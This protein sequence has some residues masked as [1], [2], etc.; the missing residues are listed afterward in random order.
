VGLD[1]RK[2]RSAVSKKISI[3]RHEG[4]PQ[5]QSVATAVSME[6][7]HRL[8]PEGDYIH[9]RKKKRAKSSR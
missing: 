1:V 3:L 7:A 4:T 5:K 8:T 9:A 2:K 6:R